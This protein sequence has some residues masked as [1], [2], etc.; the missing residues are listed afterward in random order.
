MLKK[1]LITL[2]SIIV[3]FIAFV[4][5]QPSQFQVTRSIKITAAADK[6]FDYIDTQ[7]KW[8]EWSP[9]AQ[10]DPNAEKFFGGAVNGVGSFYKWSGNEKIGAGTSTIIESKKN[11]FIKFRLDFEK[12]MKSTSISEFSFVSMESEGSTL[13]TWT[14]Y[15]EKNFMAKLFGLFMNCEEMVGSEFEKGLAN[16]KEVVERK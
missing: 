10:M 12:P 1:I 3:L 16:L 15:G 9:W 2:A 7:T 14:M 11:E 5:L 4:A 13:V 8:E 6:I